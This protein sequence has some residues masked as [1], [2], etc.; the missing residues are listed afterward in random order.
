MAK[1]IKLNIEQDLNFLLIGIV[2]SEPIYRLSWLINEIVDIKL[3]ESR[4]IQHHHKKTKELQNFSVFSFE[5]DENGGLYELIQNKAVN[6]ALIE[7]QKSMDYLF[8]ISNA[9]IDYVEFTSLIKRIENINL[10]H[11]IEP[12][13]LKSKSRLI[14]SIDES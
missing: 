2:T 10:A 11:V 7:E 12:G 1:A 3:A 13:S 4:S 8:K 14:S 6:G 9:D 5:D